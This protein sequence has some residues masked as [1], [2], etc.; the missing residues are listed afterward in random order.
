MWDILAWIVVGGLAGV[1]AARLL[2]E[3]HIGVT[4]NILIGVIGASTGGALL[5]LLQPASF[6]LSGLNVLSLI[7]AV[8]GAILLLSIMRGLM[9][10]RRSPA[11]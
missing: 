2:Q 10:P 6:V 8:S 3:N 1:A 11:Q 7:V 5:T 9:A 4:L